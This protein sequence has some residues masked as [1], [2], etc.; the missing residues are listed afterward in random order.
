MVT[1]TTKKQNTGNVD[2]ESEHSDWDGLIEADG[3]RPNESGNSF[4]SKE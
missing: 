4:V 1:A 3:N 2:G